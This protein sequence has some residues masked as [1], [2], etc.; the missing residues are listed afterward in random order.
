MLLIVIGLW[1]IIVRQRFIS[2][3]IALLV[4]VFFII[5]RV[6]EAYPTV[7]PGLTPDFTHVFWPF[8]LIA[9]GLLMIMGK[10]FGP[11]W[12]YNE[13]NRQP[14][15]QQHHRYKTRSTGNFSKNSVF[16]NGEHIV[17]D[18]VFS[19]GEM[20]AVFGGMTIDLRRTTLKD[21]YNFV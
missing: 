10:V 18:P 21:S 20:N 9:A 7:F 13:W 17:L 8:L 3:T 19:G 4:G 5:P 11:K 1:K 14:R 12:T 6:I 2:G 15:Y 16:G